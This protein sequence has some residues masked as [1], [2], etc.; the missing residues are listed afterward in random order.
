MSM[1]TKLFKLFVLSLLLIV[2]G[3]SLRAEDLRK[4]VSLSGS[5]RF[6][7]GDDSKWASPSYDDS[8]WDQINVPGKWEDQGY[9]DY[10]GYAWYRKSFKMNDIPLNTSIY[11]MLGR[12][13]DADEVYLN[14]TEIGKSGNCLLYTSPSP[15]DGLLSRM[16]SS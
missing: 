2:T 9:N 6:S 8:G 3:I 1:K 4:I 10:N 12:I 16:P 11:L 13:D 5:W 15:R 14:G 7:I